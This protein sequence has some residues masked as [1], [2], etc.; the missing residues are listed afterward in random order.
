[1]TKIG[2]IGLGMMGATHLDAYRK[3]DRADV[4]AV[5]DRNEDRRTG[6]TAAAGNIE[7]QAQ[8]GFD[9]STVKQYADADALIADPEVKLVDICLPTP[10][11]V[12][13][14]IRALEA[15]KHV[16]IEKPIARTAEDAD[17]LVAAAKSAEGLAMCAMCMRFWPGWDWLK[18]AIH[19]QT[20]GKT[21]SAHFR[22][23]TS[24][25]GGPFYRNG[26]ACGGALLDLH[27]HDTDFVQHAFGP[28]RAVFSQGHTGQSGEIAHVVT[29]YL[30]GDDGPTV[31]A[32]GSWAMAEGFGFEMQYTVNFEKATAVFDLGD[33]QPLQ[34]FGPDGNKTPVELPD[35][36]GYDHELAYFLDC[37][38]RGEAPTVVSLEDAAR[39]L[40]LVEAE[41]QSITTG[42]PVQIDFAL[43]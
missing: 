33:E 38:A 23:V 29:Q 28:P 21:R 10:A 22:R 11:H 15:G 36:M 13:C 31:S 7:G 24:H 5:A 12:D 42:Q 43:R 6:K 40:R 16:L 19:Q 2:V 17:R 9:F 1:M 4:I 37:V 41:A 30:F 3:L 39:S 26:E 18:H 8:G 35:G 20:Y 25:P 27:V 14:A 34:L 32:E